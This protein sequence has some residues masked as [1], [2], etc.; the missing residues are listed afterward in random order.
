MFKYALKKL[1]TSIPVLLGVSLLVF[2]IIHLTP[3]DPAAIILGADADEQSIAALRHKLGLD[4]P[5]YVQYGKFLLRLAQGDLGTSIRSNQPVIRELGTRYPYTVELA[6]VSLVISVVIGLLAGIVSAVKKGTIADTLSMTGALV[7]VSAPSFWIGLMLMLLFAYYLRWLP[8]SGRGGP[9]W[10]VAG[11]KTIILPAVALGLGAA[12]TIARMTRSSLLEVLNQDYIRT[13]RAKGLT[14][15]IVVYR[16][17]MANAMIPVV[18]IVGLRLGFLL[19]GSVIV[20]QVF[21]WPGVGTQ[22][23]T[24][25]G[26]RDFP[27][28]QAAVLVIA[29]SFVLINLVVDLLYGTLDPRIRYD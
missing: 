28:V 26:N 10:T 21:A 18:T 1:L 22:I 16:H 11:W 15:R 5:L 9:L 25:I 13:A 19:G 23:I 27:V 14:E 17:A 8:A 20:E 24:A 6:L 4:Q 7:G 3:G 29:L 12:A 2:L